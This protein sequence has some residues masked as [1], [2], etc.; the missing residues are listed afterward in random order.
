MTALGV[1]TLHLHLP[2]CQSLKEK[3]GRIK[4][5]LA[6]LHKQFNLSVAETDLQDRWQEAVISCCLINN[7]PSFVQ[8]TLDRVTRFAEASFP[9]VQLVN[10]QI[11]VF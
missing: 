4:P 2:G 11:E 9:D 8:S 6:R 3:R 10:H 5:V 1:L 7:N